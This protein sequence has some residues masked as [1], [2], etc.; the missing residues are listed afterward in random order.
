LGLGVGGV[1]GGG[2]SRSQ[3]LGAKASSE[4]TA[5]RKRTPVAPG[6]RPHD[7]CFAASP[8][9][10][11]SRRRLG[12][13]RLAKPQQHSLSL[14]TNGNP[15]V[16]RKRSVAGGTS[17]RDSVI[18]RASGVYMFFFG[19]ATCENTTLHRLAPGRVRGKFVGPLRRHKDLP[20]QALFLP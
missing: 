3:Q 6:R 20:F 10:S 19:L 12:P 16:R 18:L 2:S 5:R 4:P 11:R 15:A 8:A 13:R 14:L 7:T 1:G 17:F 9:Q